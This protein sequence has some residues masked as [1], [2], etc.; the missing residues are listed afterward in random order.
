MSRT[1]SAVKLKL[2]SIVL[3]VTKSALSITTE[4]AA[5][6]AAS[7]KRSENAR[8]RRLVRRNAQLR[9]ELQAWEEG[10]VVVATETFHRVID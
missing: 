9:H 10:R 6:A 1:E 3:T 7:R 8:A 5:R 4:R 2:G